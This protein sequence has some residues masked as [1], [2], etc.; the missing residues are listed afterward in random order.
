[1]TEWSFEP[2]PFVTLTHPAWSKAATLYQINTRQFTAEGTFAAAQREL[3]RLRAL[4]IDMLWLMPVQ[5][6]GVMHR[7]GTLGSPYAVR[8][9]RAVNP[10][11]GS[12]DDFARFVAAAHALDMRVLID[13]VANHTAWDNPLLAEHPE[14]YARDVHGAPRSTPWHDWDDIIELDYAHAALRRYMTEAMVHWVQRFDIDG[15][16]CDVADFVPTDFWVT[17]RRALEA[18]KPVFLLAEADAR[19]L[20]MAAFDMTY[21]WGWFDAVAHA[22]AGRGLAPLRGVYAGQAKSF[23][24]DGMRLTFV[25]NHD[26][27]AWDGTEFEIFGDGVRAAIVLSVIGGGMPLVYNGQEA[28]NPRRL[29][30]F[31]R[32]PIDWRTHEHG[33]LYARLIALKKQHPALW[34]AAWGAPVERLR[35]SEAEHVLALVRRRDGDIVLGLFNFSGAA[36]RVRLEDVSCHG[37]FVDA[38]GEGGALAFGPDTPIDLAPWDCRVFTGA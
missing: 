26:K 33:D 14:W 28:G 32:D 30:F 21:T 18:V 35:A 17:A 6:I 20:H 23:P 4:G 19:D 7:K 36:R 10:E 15:F 13:W 34:N 16:R 5:P 8:D 24:R 27:N 37:R 25:T 1:M 3:P 2:Q 11:F 38:L 12:D 9:Y 31:E 22:C 29:A